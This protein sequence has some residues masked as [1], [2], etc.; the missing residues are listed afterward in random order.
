METMETT[1]I[2]IDTDVLVDLLRNVARVV[3]SI[4]EMERKGC[5][6][7]TTTVN[8]FELLYGAYKSKNRQKNLTSTKTLLGRLVILKMGVASA[9]NAG[10]IYAELEQEGQP[11]GLRDAMIGSIA[12]TKGY[13]LATR[14]T[15]HFKKITGLNLIP[16]P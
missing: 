2:I 10:R 6:L 5:L 3:D 1:R 15:E 12:L 4:S 9:Q 8:A 14:N 7:A 13:G 16:I 11:I